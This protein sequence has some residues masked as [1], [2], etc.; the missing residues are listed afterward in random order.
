MK[1][2]IG[3]SHNPT[4][5]KTLKLCLK[6]FQKYTF[7][8]KEVQFE[9]HIQQF[10]PLKHK[11][12]AE[13]KN[14]S[15]KHLM[16]QGCD[17][18]YL[19]DDDCFPI[20]DLWWAP[21]IEK[22]LQTGEQHF[23]WLIPDQRKW[24]EPDWQVRVKEKQNGI[25][26]FTNCYGVCMFFTQMAVLATG[27]FDTNFGFYGHEHENYSFRLA[28]SGFCS[29]PFQSVEGIEKYIFSLDVQNSNEYES[30]LG[31]E[32]D[33]QKERV[34]NSRKRGHMMRD[35]EKSVE[36]WKKFLEGQTEIFIQL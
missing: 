16:E 5:P 8:T 34:V 17:Y 26:Y 9:L 33:K 3:I 21:F 11:S 32:Y 15:L 36:H 2:G 28:Q 35:K 19:F 31:K 6:Q 7:D 25:I 22:S 23:L 13:L 10:F 4:R 14:A 29:F 12:I 20:A 27:G 24:I 30:Q 18:I 1:I